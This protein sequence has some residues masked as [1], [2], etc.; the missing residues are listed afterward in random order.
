MA[1]NEIGRLPPTFIDAS[2]LAD[3][4]LKSEYKFSAGQI[5]YNK[6]RSVVSYNTSILPVFSLASVTVRTYYLS[7]EIYISK[8]QAENRQ[9]KLASQGNLIFMLN[10][11]KF[12]SFIS[13]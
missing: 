12:Y 5:V 2:K 3:A 13:I 11:T 9:K 10:I 1:C 7:K 6:F 4:I 8:N